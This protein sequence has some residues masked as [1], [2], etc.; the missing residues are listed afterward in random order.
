M[1]NK[2]PKLV[3]CIIRQTSDSKGE[4]RLTMPTGRINIGSTSTGGAMGLLAS[5]CSR[6]GAAR[7]ACWNILG[8]GCILMW[9][10][11]WWLFGIGR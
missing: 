5:L 11:V 4:S 9:V 8:V 2:H 6:P 10:F 3:T 1:Q 7:A